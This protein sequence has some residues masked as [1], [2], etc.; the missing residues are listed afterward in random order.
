MDKTKKSFT[1]GIFL[2]VCSMKMSTI[3]LWHRG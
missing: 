1:D 3:V 2:A